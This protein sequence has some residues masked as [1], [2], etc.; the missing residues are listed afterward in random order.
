MHLQSKK[1]SPC[2]AASITPYPR[3]SSS[4]C[5]LFSS[6]TRRIE[7]TSAERETVQQRPDESTHYALVVEDQP[8]IRMYACSILMGAGYLTLE[9]AIRLRLLDFC[10]L[11]GKLSVCSSL[12]CKCPVRKMGLRLAHRCCVGW[13]HV[14]ILITSGHVAPGPTD[15]PPRAAF[16][17]KPFDERD[18]LKA[19]NEIAVFKLLSDG[20]DAA[21]QLPSDEA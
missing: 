4:D 11:T 2:A 1:Q 19:L 12:T 16:I 6:D 17:A 20:G 7:L 18:V 8:L 14:D 9:A 3:N 10:K 13:P 21:S 15:L 5:S